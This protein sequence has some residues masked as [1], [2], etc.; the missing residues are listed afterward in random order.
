MRLVR[1]LRPALV[2]ALFAIVELHDP[3]AAPGGPAA[4]MRVG[5]HSGELRKAVGVVGAQSIELLIKSSAQGKEIHVYGVDAQNRPVNLAAS[6]YGGILFKFGDLE[7]PL[8]CD[9]VG[10][11]GY[12][13]NAADR[14]EHYRAVGKFPNSPKV[15]LE[16]TIAF[17]GKQGT[18]KVSFRPF[19]EQ[20][21][22]WR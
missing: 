5:P 1:G 19:P 18:A 11:D 7:L 10:E 4:A 15:E 2:A 8:R 21:D 20:D 22:S 12:I 16:I 14:F 3:W 17:P 9:K 6:G 13:S